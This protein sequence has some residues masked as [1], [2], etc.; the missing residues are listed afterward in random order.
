MNSPLGG[1]SPLQHVHV[2]PPNMSQLFQ[3][4]IQYVPQPI[5]VNGV[6]GNHASTDFGF[7]APFGSF[8]IGHP[9]LAASAVFTV[10]LWKSERFQGV[11]QGAVLTFAGQEAGDTFLE[12]VRSF[13]GGDRISLAEK[14]AQEKGKNKERLKQLE[15]RASEDEKTIDDLK[16]RKKNST[17][18]L[19][20]EVEELKRQLEALKIEK[21]SYEKTSAEDKLKIEHKDKAYTKLEQEYIDLKKQLKN[22]LD[23]IARLKE[24]NAELEK[25]CLEI[26]LNGRNATQQCET[27][28]NCNKK[29]EDEK[30]ELSKKLEQVREESNK[31]A[32]ELAKLRERYNLLTQTFEEHKKYNCALYTQQEAFEQRVIT[33]ECSGGLG[34]FDDPFAPSKNPVYDLRNLS[35]Q[36]PRVVQ[37]TH[38]L[39]FFGNQKL[40]VQ[41]HKKNGR[42]NVFAGLNKDDNNNF[43]FSPDQSCT[44]VNF[45]NGTLALQGDPRQLGNE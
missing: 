8:L 7:L 42:P 30:T 2:T 32:I 31:N 1:G 33:N 5:Y 41:N 21:N 11:M 34:G 19:K 15:K 45:S 25:K 36:I 12:W 29:L 16:E 18:K 22:Y 27:V 9:I 23:Q 13:W 24:K 26:S 17:D 28:A 4:P 3:Q 43:N 44:S 14:A 10:A 39:A 40:G 37:N 6:G 35:F 20:K 38:D